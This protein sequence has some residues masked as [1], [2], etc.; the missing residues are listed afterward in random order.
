MNR[1]QEHV[2]R[3]FKGIPDSERKTELM[4]EIMENLEE[5]V[6]DLMDQGKSA[7]DALNKVI[8]EFS[9]IE[10]IKQ[11]L[12]T[13][14]SAGAVSERSTRLWLN[15]SFSIWGS[16]LIIGLCLFVNLYYTPDAIWFIYPTFAVL[17]WPLVMYFHWKKHQ[18]KEG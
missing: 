15:F 5:K 11:E 3:L 17:W 14:R 4:Q 13:A 2:E 12:V 10:E 16:L 9:D 18:N 1:I 8:V 7:E 6:Q